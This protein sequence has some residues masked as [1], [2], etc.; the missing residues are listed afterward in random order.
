VKAQLVIVLDIDIDD[1][2]VGD[3]QTEA[4]ADVAR[5]VG[6]TV[7]HRLVAEGV[8]VGDVSSLIHTPK[9]ASSTP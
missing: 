1:L 8:R 4:V 6:A 5:V 7:R 9:P 3:P 2:A